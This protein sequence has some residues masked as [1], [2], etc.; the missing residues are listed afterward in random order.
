MEGADSFSSSLALPYLPAL[1]SKPLPSNPLPSNK[2]MGKKRKAAVTKRPAAKSSRLGD[3]GDDGANDC[4]DDGAKASASES[5]DDD[6]AQNG[7]AGGLGQES[8]NA[9]KLLWPF[10]KT[11]SWAS[12][13]IQYHVFSLFLL[14]F[15]HKKRPPLF[16]THIISCAQKYE[17][18]IVVACLF[19][20]WCGWERECS[21]AS[22]PLQTAVIRPCMA[23]LHTSLQGLLYESWSR[24]QDSLGEHKDCEEWDKVWEQQHADL[25]SHGGGEEAEDTW[26]GSGPWGLHS[27]A[28]W[29]LAWR[30][31]KT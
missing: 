3:G 8:N 30:A 1:P 7:E 28:S 22:W 13:C 15:L 26:G 6:D 19:C 17:F 20:R 31:P 5:H 14:V 10:R 24:C 2:P 21:E 27:W 23:Y 16:Q 4:E 25:W 9:T 12:H 18:V 29:K 11:F